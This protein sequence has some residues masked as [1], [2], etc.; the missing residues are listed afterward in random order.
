M[1][2]QS[3]YEQVVI[4][5]GRD[6]LAQMLRAEQGFEIEKIEDRQSEIHFT[7]GLS[8]PKTHSIRGE[9]RSMYPVRLH[10]V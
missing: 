4:L 2:R 5:V 7:L 9:P 6:E 10:P 8:F 1:I 3:R